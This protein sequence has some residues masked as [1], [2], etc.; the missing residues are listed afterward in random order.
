MSDTARILTAL[1][2]I[3]EAQDRLAEQVH[4]VSASLLH[5]F[6][7]RTHYSNKR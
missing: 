6:P 7:L 4:A 1:E 5:R 2:R 3:E